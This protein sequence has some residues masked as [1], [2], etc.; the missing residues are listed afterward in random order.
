VTVLKAP[1][2]EEGT[3]LERL[4]AEYPAHGVIREVAVDA[5]RTVEHR[6]W[7]PTPSTARW[8]GPTTV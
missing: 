5:R 4:F 3:Q 2:R 8:H 1:S 6:S 7:S